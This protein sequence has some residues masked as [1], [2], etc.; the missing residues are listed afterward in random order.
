MNAFIQLTRRNILTYLNDKN[1]VFFSFLNI[2]ILIMLYFL[3]IGKQYTYGLNDI[4][5]DLQRIVSIAT[6]VGGIFVINT[7]NL[8]LG[9]SGNLVIDKEY[10]K[11]HSFLSTPVERWKIIYSY[12]FASVLITIVMTIFMW[13]LVYFFLGLYLDFWYSLNVLLSMIG[14]LFIYCLISSSLTIFVASFLKTTRSFATISQLLGT[15]IGFLCGIYMPIY[16]LGKDIMK[17]VIFIP[18]TQMTIAIKQ[19][20]LN[21]PYE[22]LELAGVNDE[23]LNILK[24]IHGYNNLYFFDY[25]VQPQMIIIISTLASILLV[26]LSLKNISRKIVK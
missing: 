25:L 19:I 8:S 10:H 7:I 1:A 18:F 20:L 4:D 3:F 24:D 26:A 16:I 17:L 12:Y 9:I 5:G 21:K 14:L 2:I 13:I 22:N 15:T 6:L 23:T 11:V